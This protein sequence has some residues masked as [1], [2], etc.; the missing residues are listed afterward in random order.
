[1]KNVEELNKPKEEA[2]VLGLYVYDI[3]GAAS[4]S[5][6]LVNSAAPVSICLLDSIYLLAINAIKFAGG[7][8]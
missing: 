5:A 1:M 2:P 3:Q 7:R 8:E 6:S 4:N